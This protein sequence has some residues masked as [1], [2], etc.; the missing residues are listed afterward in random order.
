M[1]PASVGR[2]KIAKLTIGSKGCRRC[3]AASLEPGVMRKEQTRMA[4]LIYDFKKVYYTGGLSVALS[5]LAVY[6][7][8]N[9]EIH[10]AIW[11]SSILIVFLVL[12][13]LGLFRPKIFCSECKSN[14][15]R[16]IESE[17][18]EN[19]KQEF[20]VCPTCGIAFNE[21]KKIS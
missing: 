4:S 17:Y 20:K 6:L 3:R 9:S 10:P 19:K 11:I 15:Y 13:Y 16:E 14:L 5:F 18:K 2:L 21:P 8:G 7:L 12:Q 1:S